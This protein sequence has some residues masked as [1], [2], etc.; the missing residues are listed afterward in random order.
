MREV[1]RSVATL[2]LALLAVVE[3]GAVSAAPGIQTGSSWDEYERGSLETTARESGLAME[4]KSG[5]P[6]LTFSGKSFPTIA[7]VQ[8]TGRVRAIAGMRREQIDEYARTFAPDDVTYFPRLRNEVC[9]LEGRREHWL[10]VTEDTLAFMPEELAPGDTFSVWVRLRGAVANAST[11]SVVFTLHQFESATGEPTERFRPVVRRFKPGSD[12]GADLAVVTFRVVNIR[13]QPDLG[14]AGT[15]VGHAIEGSTLA[16]LDRRPSE[17][18]YHVVD[19]ESG[20]EGWVHGSVIE[21][22]YTDSTDRPSGFTA[23]RTGDEGPPSVVV[24]NQTHLE[25]NLRLG[26]VT[27]KIDPGLSRQ[28]TVEPGAF[29]Y[30]A[31]VA[32]VIPKNGEQSFESGFRYTWRFF[33]VRR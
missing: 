4:P 27:Y 24:T 7:Q 14:D 26:K 28:I 6:R 17:P 30:H 31:W 18:W 25:L 20:I 3:A 21:V 1:L 29:A 13:A 9:V 10:M 19:V 8:Y 5:K 11:A 33:I 32:G 16:V 2:V 23:E 22:Y 15:V 12:P